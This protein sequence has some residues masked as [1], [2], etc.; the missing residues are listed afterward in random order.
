MHPKYVNMIVMATICLHN[1]IKSEEHRMHAN[2]RVYCPPYY[3]DSE[4]S[5]GNIIPGEWRRCTENSLQDIP[6]TSRHH[7]ATIAY[8]QR[9]KLAEY[10]LTSSGQLPW[11]YDYVRRGQHRDDP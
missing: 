4:D 8:K 11:Q 1:F 5:E 9:D 6:F 3:T 10:F 2:D 7:G